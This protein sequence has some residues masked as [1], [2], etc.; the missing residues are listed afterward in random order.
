[1]SLWYKFEH[2]DRLNKP[3]EIRAIQEKNGIVE[4]GRTIEEWAEKIGYYKSNAFSSYDI[5]QILL[6]VESNYQVK[7]CCMGVGTYTKTGHP[8]LSPQDYKTMKDMMLY[9]TYICFDTYLDCNKFISKFDFHLLNVTDVKMYYSKLQRVFMYCLGRLESKD[10]YKRLSECRNNLLA[11]RL[12]YDFIRQ[13]CIPQNVFTDLIPAITWY[14]FIYDLNKEIETVLYNWNQSPEGYLMDEEVLEKLIQE[15]PRLLKEYQRKY[16]IAHKEFMEE[17]RRH[18]EEMEEARRAL[19]ARMEM[20]D[21]ACDRFGGPMP[22]SVV[23]IL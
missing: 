5:A 19:D 20:Y 2:K 12:A 16:K 9:A 4:H 7:Y 3:Y 17:M 23:S 15:Q 14:K 10:V 18:R 21:K 8:K 13:T 6:K 11:V 1:M 22:Y